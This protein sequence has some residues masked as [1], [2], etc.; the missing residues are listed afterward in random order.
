MSEPLRIERIAHGGHAVAHDATGRVVFVRHALPGELVR[1]MPLAVTH[2]RYAFA[3]TLEVLQ[4]SPHRVTPSCPVANL[5]GGCD[6]QQVSLAEQRRLKTEVVVGLLDR[7]AVAHP[8][9][10][11]V[12]LP[13]E[14]AG[15]H[16]RT[17]M[18]YQVTLGPDGRPIVGL[19]AYHTRTVV[20]LPVTGCLLAADTALM[21]N[22]LQELAQ[23]A[24]FH[25]AQRDTQNSDAHLTS[26]DTATARATTRHRKLTQ[27]PGNRTHT[28]RTALGDTASSV[29]F[30]SRL[31]SGSQQLTQSVLGRS[32]QVDASDF[33]QVHPGAPV[34]F[35]QAV[36]AGLDPQPGE[37]ALDLYCGSGLLSGVLAARGVRVTGIDVSRNAIAC[38]RSNVPEATFRCERVER[39]KL[40]AVDLV[41]L[42]PSRAGAKRRVVQAIAAA[43]PRR[44]VYVACDPAAL[45]RDLTYFAAYGYQVRAIQA[46]DAFPMTHH[47]ET[48]VTLAPAN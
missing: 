18:D 29:L 38:A 44:V 36:L 15:F 30:D 19:Y 33:W 6:F 11:V 41:V 39:A 47:V 27:H 12:A 5:C 7:G 24:L 31:L 22:Q 20:P 14:L 45:V 28:L 21:P 34:A 48:V 25:S 4:P 8:E 40:P 23:E 2:E 10:Q 32:Y 13:G 42:D 16:W 9:F 1:V 46:F 3:D 35:A 26:A 17:R 37:R 43:K